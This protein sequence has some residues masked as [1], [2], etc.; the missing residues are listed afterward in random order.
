MKG[1]TAMLGL[2]AP[3]ILIL[4]VII[5]L[6]FGAKRLPEMG[7][8]VAKGIKEFK[9]GMSDDEPEEV[10]QEPVTP[11]EITESSTGTATSKAEIDE[12]E[13][14]LAR[15]KAELAALERT[16]TPDAN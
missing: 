14:E 16:N 11:K 13:R 8:S 4:V 15:K 6:V 10:K 3:E 1:N 9:K 12:I 2:H 5:L 7:S